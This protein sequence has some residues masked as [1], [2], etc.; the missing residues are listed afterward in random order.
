MRDLAILKIALRTMFVFP[1]AGPPHPHPLP[2]H[3]LSYP[4]TKHGTQAWDRN[5]RLPNNLRFKVRPNPDDPTQLRGVVFHVPCLPP[6]GFNPDTQAI[7]TVWETTHRLLD[8]LTSPPHGRRYGMIGDRNR[9]DVLKSSLAR[10]TLERAP[11]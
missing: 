3:W 5:A 2:R 1:N 4:I 10:L 9:R 8:E 7:L 11:E 6:A